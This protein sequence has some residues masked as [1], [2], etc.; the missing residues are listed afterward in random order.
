MMIIDFFLG[1]FLD[2][3]AIVMITFP[4]YIPLAVQLGFD[5]LWFTVATAV[6]LQDSFCTPPFGYNLFYLKGCA[7]PEI[8]SKDIVVGAVPFWMLMEFGMVIICLFPGLITWLPSVI[9][10]GGAG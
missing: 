9:V 8:S 7:P 2:W 1:M 6:M 5:P 4:V 3:T 10:K